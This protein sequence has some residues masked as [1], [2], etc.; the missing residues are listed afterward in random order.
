MDISDT[1]LLLC[2]VQKMQKYPSDISVSENC[3]D[4]SERPDPDN[5]L[6]FPL[7]EWRAWELPELI[8]R[9]Y[10]DHSNL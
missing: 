1:L 8:L 4:W 9:Q 2:F 7:Q 5:F 6:C 10:S 3:I